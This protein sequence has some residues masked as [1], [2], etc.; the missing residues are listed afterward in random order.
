MRPDPLMGSSNAV[1]VPDAVVAHDAMTGNSY[2]T[3]SLSIPVCAVRPMSDQFLTPI[4]TFRRADEAARKGKLDDAITLYLDVAQSSPGDSASL[5]R[6][7]DIKAW[8]NR[9][10]SSS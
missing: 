5:A 2:T 8:L 7:N 3:S 1:V 9:S 6:I 4:E 10:D